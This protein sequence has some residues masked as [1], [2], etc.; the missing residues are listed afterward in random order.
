MAVEWGDNRRRVGFSE[1]NGLRTLL[2]G[3]ATANDDEIALALLGYLIEHPGVAE[4]LLVDLP[5]IV[6]R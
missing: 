2:A 5:K 6:G 4:K 1:L 3:V